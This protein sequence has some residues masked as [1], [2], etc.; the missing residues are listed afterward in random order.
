MQAID[1]KKSRIFAKSRVELTQK[2]KKRKGCEDQRN[3]IDKFNTVFMPGVLEETFNFSASQSGCGDGD[4]EILH[5]TSADPTI[6]MLTSLDV[7]C[8][9]EKYSKCAQHI[10]IPVRLIRIPQNQKTRAEM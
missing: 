10:C 9:N 2:K 4:G 5:F 8:T 3:N 6:L 1:T 7:E